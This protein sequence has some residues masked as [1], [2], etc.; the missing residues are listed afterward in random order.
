MSES[1]EKR[2][3]PDDLPKPGAFK[4]K[5]VFQH[6]QPADTGEPLKEGST[7]G[8]AGKP[9][10]KTSDEQGLN[11]EQSSANAG[12]FEGFEDQGSE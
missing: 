5:E 6:P 2:I 9:G 10:E 7:P 8:T 4:K 11:E 12:A 3:N 1:N